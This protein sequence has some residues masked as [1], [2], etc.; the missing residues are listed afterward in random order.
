M[1]ELRSEIVEVL[2][3][4]ED[5]FGWIV[6][7]REEGGGAGFES[8]DDV[9]R[10]RARQR[11]FERSR[12]V[13]DLLVPAARLEGLVEL[14]REPVQTTSPACPPADVQSIE[15]PAEAG[16]SGFVADES[17]TVR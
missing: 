15:E 7:L 11:T 8:Q 3:V 10:A 6:C 2:D 16:Q 4:V 1:D 9:G 17:R 12:Q 14:G 13:H 5:R